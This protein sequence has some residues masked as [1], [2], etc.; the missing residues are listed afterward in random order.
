MIYWGI[1]FW[2]ISSGYARYTDKTVHAAQSFGNVEHG[3]ELFNDGDDLRRLSE[4]DVMQRRIT[5]TGSAKH[6]SC[7]GSNNG[8]WAPFHNFYQRPV[9]ALVRYTTT[10][11]GSLRFYY[12]LESTG[13]SYYVGG[14]T[15]GGKSMYLNFGLLPSGCVDRVVFLLGSDKVK[16]YKLNGITFYE[17]GKRFHWMG[18]R[19]GILYQVTAPS[20]RCLGDVRFRTANKGISYLCL[21]FNSY[22]CMSCGKDY[23]SKCD[24]Y[25]RKPHQCVRKKVVTCSRGYYRSFSGGRWSCKRCSKCPYGSY[26][27]LG[28]KGGMNTFCMRCTRCRS[29]YFQ[30]RACSQMQDT[31]CEQ[32][33]SC[34]YGYYRRYNRC[35]R[36]RRC[37]PGYILTRRC[38]KT[39]DAVCTYCSWCNRRNDWL[40]KL[41]K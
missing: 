31:V 33:K 28:C 41:L 13:K 36:C 21:R 14:G 39:Q 7:Y 34:R 16:G 15:H 5:Q 29:G 2:I 40:L 35:Y 8:T 30:K 10:A 6:F 26:Q 11:I 19:S 17:G 18:G 38:S 9:G 1:C 22:K 27:R 20:G 3:D 4:N 23:E 24:K 12:K 25:G 37:R 32:Y